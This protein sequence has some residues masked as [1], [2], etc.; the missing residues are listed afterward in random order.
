MQ[1]EKERIFFVIDMKTFF[2]SVECA[3]R[4]LDPFKTCL[5]VSDKSSGSGA[6]CLAITPKMK[7]MGIRNRCR[8]FEIPHNLDYIIAKPRMKKYIE[9]A[10]EI[11]AIYLKHIDKN[12]I[13]IYSIDEAFIDATD[14]LKL[15]KLTP[16]EFAVKL[17]AEISNKL[18]IPSTV[19]IGTNMYLAKIALD[20]T[21]KHSPD[22]IGFLDEE[23]YK[24]KLWKHTPI[25]DFWQ[26]SYGTEKRL[27]KNNIHTME[28]VAKADE[29]LLYKEFGINAELLIDHAWGRETCTIADIKN[30]KRKSLSMS[31]SQTL[32]KDYNYED[33][34][35]VMREMMQN[36]CDE[37]QRHQ[38]V[39]QLVHL[40]IRYSG[41]RGKSVKG[42]KR[43]TVTTNLY[44]IIIKYAEKIFKEIVDKQEK[45]RKIGFSFGD[46]HDETYE[47]YD[48]FT[49]L[50]QIKKEKK[51][52]SSV[53]HIKDKFGK[54]AI[55][56]GI[57]LQEN[58][59]QIQRN[60]KTGG[61]NS[62]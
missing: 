28:D 52:T 11:Y 57:D 56:K 35:L 7:Q 43:M 24:K 62:E 16:K 25:T 50:K 30:Y 46:L 48:L 33:A 55:L 6:L 47:Q 41:E 9:Y 49:D 45:V 58:A 39:T 18:H 14:Y 51:M 10:A 23:E 5:V 3:E 13:H 53:L 22:F 42:T 20:I 31:S 4:G 44:S 27:S 34:M 37:L 8:M 40:S 1:A 26:I 17:M 21:A 2:A 15:Y 32:P 59:T 12:D 38:F 36:G 19:G 54:N 29:K 61:H 60:T